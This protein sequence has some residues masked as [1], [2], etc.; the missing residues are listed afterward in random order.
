MQ[1]PDFET[2]RDAW[3][4]TLAG[5]V[6][7][8]DADRLA[9]LFTFSGKRVQQTASLALARATLRDPDDPKPVMPDVL[10]AGRDLTTPNMQRFA[11]PIEPRYG[12]DDLVLPADQ[13]KQLH[14]VAA[15]FQFRSIVHRDW[16]F[17]TK[18]SR[19]RG[20]SVLFTG[21][22]GTGKTMAAEVLARD[23]SLRLFQ[24]DLATVVSKYIGETEA[25]LERD[26]P[27]GGTQPEPAVFRRSRCAVRQAHRGQGCARPI[28]QHRSELPATAHRAISAAWSCW[29]PIS[30]RISTMRSCGGFIASCDSLFRTSERREQI[31]R[32]QFPA[33]APLTPEVDFAFL[34]S[35]FKLAGGNIRNVAIEAAF[36]AAQEAGADGPH[37]DG[38]H[39]RR[40]QARIPEAGQVGHEGRSGPVLA[41]VV[42]E[43]SGELVARQQASGRSM[44][45]NRKHI[46]IP[47]AKFHR[48]STDPMLR[49]QRTVGNRAIQK[50]LPRSEGEPIAGGSGGIGEYVRSG[51][52]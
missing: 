5:S 34:A 19:G 49:L 48:R 45:S 7:D 52:E 35:Q 38:P 9:D 17:G 13:T 51:S 27:R 4:A 47:E 41:C 25:N 39:H 20:L 3:R 12:W 28:R 24:I 37:L 40:P 46:A 8:V 29:P 42:K 26:L 33:K 18:L 32:L 6:P 30:R 50:M 22:T 23:L 11:I 14:A 36:L 16:D 2:R 1:G 15:R 21:P 43:E 31:W 44:L 10:A